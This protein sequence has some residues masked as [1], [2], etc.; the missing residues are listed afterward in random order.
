MEAILEE[1][2]VRRQPMPPPISE[3]HAAMRERVEREWAAL[4]EQFPEGAVDVVEAVMENPE[5]A[6]P[7]AEVLGLMLEER[8]FLVSQGVDPRPWGW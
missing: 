8:D 2:R 4:V 5:L 7:A 6:S 3:E 1:D